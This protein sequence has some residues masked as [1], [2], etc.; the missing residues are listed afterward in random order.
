MMPHSEMEQG[1]QKEKQSI[2]LLSQIKTDISAAI[3]SFPNIPQ[4]KLIMNF[5]DILLEHKGRVSEILSPE[6]KGY[7]AMDAIWGNAFTSLP[8][9]EKIDTYIRLRKLDDNMKNELATQTVTKLYEDYLKSKKPL[10]N[11]AWEKFVKASQVFNTYCL[12]G[13]FISH[14]QDDFFSEAFGI[15]L[16]K[17][18]DESFRAWISPTKEDYLR[19][20]KLQEEFAKITGIL[21]PDEMWTD[22][23]HRPNIKIV[24]FGY[25]AGDSDKDLILGELRT[26]YTDSFNLGGM[27]NCYFNVPTRHQNV[28]STII[29]DK[30]SD[31]QKYNDKLDSLIQE[32]KLTPRIML[33]IPAAEFAE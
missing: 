12:D 14:Y 9:K 26:S 32:G 19:N 22:F 6:T 24:N 5:N 30:P 7:G 27:P 18:A 33:V 31:N 1:N 2:S 17:I 21:R 4:E 29:F 8:L 20:T 13:K 16:P 28:M 15:N 10:S 3:K 23:V 25:R 11:G